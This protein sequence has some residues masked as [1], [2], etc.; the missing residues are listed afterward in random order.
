MSLSW[1]KPQWHMASDVTTSTGPAICAFSGKLH[2]VWK[3]AANNTI[4]HS[5][6]DGCSWTS[7]AVI[8]GAQ[9]TMV[10]SLATATFS[11]TTRLYMA[12]RNAAN[13]L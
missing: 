2:M 5:S 7:A 4:W 12:W 13:Q 11:G 3:S 1:I 10:P 8:P 6:F 9:T